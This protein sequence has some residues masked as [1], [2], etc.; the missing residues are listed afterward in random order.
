MMI[1]NAKD[2]M[3]SSIPYFNP[4][5][6]VTDILSSDLIWHSFLLGFHLPPRHRLHPDHPLCLVSIDSLSLIIIC[7]SLLLP[8]CYLCFLP[9]LSVPISLY[10]NH[11]TVV[12]W[13]PFSESV[14]EIVYHPLHLKG[15]LQC[16]LNVLYEITFALNLNPC[17]CA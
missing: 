4:L 2:K 15:K 1:L 16:K 6:P 3:F 7:P 9:S 12:C 14:T 8:P 13:T 5:A 17:G 11:R 10:T